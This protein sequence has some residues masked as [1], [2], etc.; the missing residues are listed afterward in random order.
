MEEAP[1]DGGC[2]VPFRW[3]SSMRPERDP[4][5]EQQPTKHAEAVP[6]GEAW[7][8]VYLLK[9]DGPENHDTSALSVRHGVMAAINTAPSS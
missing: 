5:T 1:T 4:T 2:R 8:K 9:Q 3:A 6:S 7:N